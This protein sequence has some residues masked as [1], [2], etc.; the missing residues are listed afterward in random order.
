MDFYRPATRYKIKDIFYN[1][2]IDFEEEDLRYTFNYKKDL[3][4]IMT[5]NYLFVLNYNRFSVDK[6]MRIVLTY[7]SSDE[8]PVYPN[9]FLVNHLPSFFHFNR[10]IKKLLKLLILIMVI[11]FICSFALF[12]RRRMTG[13]KSYGGSEA[14]KENYLVDKFSSIF[15]LITRKKSVREDDDAFKEGTY[16]KESRRASRSPRRRRHKRNDSLSIRRKRAK[17]P[18]KSR[19]K[20]FKVNE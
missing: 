12:I 4:V 6:D 16:E 11:I 14:E 15:S 1:S 18:A 3:F 5:S 10:S 8:F 20:K 19:L 2:P 9:H 7:S 13:L 17:S